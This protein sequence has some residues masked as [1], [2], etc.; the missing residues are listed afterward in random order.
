VNSHSDVEDVLQCLGRDWPE[1]DSIVEGVMRELDSIPPRPLEKPVEKPVKKLVPWMHIRRILAVAAAVAVCAG[2]WWA[3]SGN[4]SVYAQTRDAI[5]RARSFQ[6]T[7]RYFADGEDGALSTQTLTTAFERGVGFREEW[8]EELSVGNQ[9]GSWHY[10]K[11]AKL[12]IKTKGLDISRMVDRFLD[13]GLGKTFDGAAYERCAARDQVVDGQ[14]CQAFLIAHLRQKLAGD[15]DPDR[16]RLI[17]LKDNQSRIAQTIVEVRPADRWIVRAVS[18][19]KYD[20]PLDP[21]LFQPTFPDDVRVVD[22]DTAFE[23]FV[24]LDH[25]IY[26]EERS[27]LWYAIHHAE[28]IENGGLFLVTSAR[29]TEATLKKYPLTERPLAPGKLF[30]DGPASQYRPGADGGTPGLF[31]ELASV[32]HLGINVSWWVALPHNQAAQSPFETADG[33]VNVPVVISPSFSP[34]WKDN[35][36][37]RDGVTHGLAWVIALDLP[38]PAK[39]PTLDSISRKVYAD[40]EVLEGVPF[41]FPNMG[42]RGLRPARWYDLDKITSAQFA[43]AVAD[44]VRWWQN[45]A[46]MDDPR[47]RE[48]RGTPAPSK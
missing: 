18:D 27:G 33:K 9:G 7:A 46:P 40:L 28:R 13:Q 20:V 16:Q 3:S 4:T 12:A 17:V 36:T 11:G 15:V 31:I 1:N 8:P 19:L 23:S 32:D 26:R 14:P 21:A 44:D 43:E 6:M 24:D 47:A 5:R 34:Y 35:F 41:K 10:R 37:D 30:L 29:G 39:S 2:L 22:A 45:G 38:T 25:A 48:L 42:N